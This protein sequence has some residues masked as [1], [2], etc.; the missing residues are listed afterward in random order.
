MD[1]RPEGSWILNKD[2]SLTPNLNDPAMAELNAMTPGGLK[3]DYREVPD[4]T[5]AQ[6]QPEIAQEDHNND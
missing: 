5:I 1:R 3:T 4:A 2:G 6:D